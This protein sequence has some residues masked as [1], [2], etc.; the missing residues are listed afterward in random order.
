M[1]F[2]SANN[3]FVGPPMTCFRRT[4][5]LLWGW[6]RIWDTACRE[7][8][9]KKKRQEPGDTFPG[10]GE[11]EGGGGFLVALE[12]LSRAIKAFK[13]LIRPVRAL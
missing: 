1:F 3:L 6:P 5:Y 13:V 12:G 2:G 11:D 10:G 4:K 8:I 7:H 9:N